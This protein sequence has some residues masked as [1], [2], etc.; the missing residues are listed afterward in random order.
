MEPLYDKPGIAGV[1][2]VIIVTD[3]LYLHQC[4]S[5]APYWKKQKWLSMDGKPIENSD[6]WNE[7]ITLRPKL[8]VAHEI[9]WS[10]GKTSPILKEVD[11]RAKDAAK[12]PTETDWGFRGGKVGRSKSKSKRASIL[13]PAQGQQEVINIYRKTASGKN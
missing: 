12:C 1:S 6:L 5:S 13:F 2:R 11:R 9:Q 4:L 7:I 10:K 8:R 3:S